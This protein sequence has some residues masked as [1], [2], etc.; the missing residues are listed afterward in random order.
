MFNL[1]ASRFLSQNI[2]QTLEEL[3]NPSQSSWPTISQWID[4]ARNTLTVVKKDEKSADRE[5]FSMQMPTSS[6]LG[7]VI[8]ETG[9]ILAHHGWLRILGS[10]N[11]ALPRGLM[12]WNFSKSF[13]QSG[14]KPKYLLVADD[15]IGGYFAL[16]GGSLG[17]NLGKVYYFSPKDN[18]WHDLN[19]SYSE[20]LLWAFNGDIEAFYQHLFWENWQ[21]DVKHL[22]GNSVFVFIPDLSEDSV[23]PIDKREKREVSIETHYNAAFAAKDKFAQAYSV[24]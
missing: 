18:L 15:V 24:A 4:N 19:F 7:A 2:M 5:L 21:E 16:N 22:D 17:N 12:D 9:G 13:Q 1:K 20:F 23:T 11:F 14:D 8:Y 10:G 3:T 6:P